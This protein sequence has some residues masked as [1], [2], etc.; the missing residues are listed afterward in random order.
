[1]K[2]DEPWGYDQALWGNRSTGSL[3][4]RHPRQTRPKLRISCKSELRLKKG[5][6]VV[7]FDIQTF[8]QPAAKGGIPPFANVL[9]CSAQSGHLSNHLSK[10]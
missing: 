9:P 3:S 5:L 10:Q 6:P 2:E 8:S 7:T 4:A 1:M